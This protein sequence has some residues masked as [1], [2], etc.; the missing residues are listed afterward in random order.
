MKLKYLTANTTAP[1]TLEDG[2]R[3]PKMGMEQWGAT[4][5]D[6]A[7][8]LHYPAIATKK[9]CTAGRVQ[10]T[11]SG[12][13]E[14]VEI[15]KFSGSAESSTKYPLR[16][17]IELKHLVPFFDKSFNSVSPSIRM[18]DANSGTFTADVECYGAVLVKYATQFNIMEYYPD[19]KTSVDGYVGQTGGTTT[20]GTIFSYHVETGAMAELEVSPPEF[21]PRNEFEVYTIYSEYV[22]DE[23]GRHEKPDDWDTDEPKYLRDPQAEVPEKDGSRLNERVYKI[24]FINPQGTF[25]TKHLSSTAQNFEPFIGMANYHP[26]YYFRVASMPESP[27]WAKKAYQSLDFDKLFE[28]EQQYFEDIE[29]K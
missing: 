19:F 17:V 29:R 1:V 14:Q 5:N 26:Q 28:G 27:E 10:V 8:V 6:H 22:T 2:T 20:W 4:Y 18:I 12:S 16:N 3:Q 24:G 15:I 25:L 9:V 23:N 7:I 13:N 11:G 21:E